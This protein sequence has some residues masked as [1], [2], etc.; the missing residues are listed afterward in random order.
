[1]FGRR[2]DG[3]RVK[4]LNVIDKAE[5]FFMPMR[6]DAVNYFNMKINCEGL[7]NF[8]KKERENGN[9]F[10]YMHI[11]I[12]SI[13]RILYTRERMNWFIMNGVIYQRKGI[14]VS[15]DIKKSLSDDGEIVTLKFPFKGTENLFEV[16]DIV[17]AE[18]AK[19][20]DKSEEHSTTKSAGTLA[21]L[22]AW[23]FRMA[24]GMLRFCDKHGILTGLMLKLSPFHTSCFLTNL[25]SIKLNYVYHHLYNFGTTSIFMSMGKEQMEPVVLENNKLGVAK[26]MNFGLSLDER[27][28]DG[29]YMGKS[30]RIFE[31]LLKNPEELL[32]K[33]PEKQDD[34]KKKSKKKK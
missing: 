23:M 32:E 30:M 11:V 29:L 31:N 4:N 26:I 19:N 24:M 6:I 17:N 8:I 25:K 27:I 2:K 9:S 5:P 3:K 28:A 7:D 18:I 13:V 10:S 20:L 33:L 21:K 12:A 16:R 22:P 34:T 14:Y 15:M 1:M